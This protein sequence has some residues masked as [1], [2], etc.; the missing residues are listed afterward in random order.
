MTVERTLRG[1]VWTMH[2]QGCP[3]VEG[4]G[5]TVAGEEQFGRMKNNDSRLKRHC[6]CTT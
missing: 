1:S 6:E 5:F 3:E 4:V 2:R